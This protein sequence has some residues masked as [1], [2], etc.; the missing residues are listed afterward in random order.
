[1]S[2]HPQLEHA[3]IVRPVCKSTDIARRRPEHPDLPG[4]RK[5][6]ITS[7]ARARMCVRIHFGPA[8]ALTRRLQESFLAGPTDKKLIHLPVRRQCHQLV[9]F[10]RTKKPRRNKFEIGNLSH[11]LNIYSNGTGRGHRIHDEIAR[12]RSIEVEWAVIREA[13][14]L[15]FPEWT[16]GEIDRCRTS[17]QVLTEELPENPATDDERIAIV[18]RAEL[19]G[20]HALV[21]RQRGLEPRQ[22]SKE[23]AESRAPEMNLMGCEA[24]RRGRGR[25]QSCWC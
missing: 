10:K 16:R 2:R 5:V 13:G 21:R 18:G 14:D 7:D 17:T 8:E 4:A 12:A 6:R 24:H 11:T 1:M 23:I 9:G 15:W 25:P 19:A 22:F 3:R 20:A